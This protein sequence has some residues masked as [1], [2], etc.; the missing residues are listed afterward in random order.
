MFINLLIDILLE[1]NWHLLPWTMEN[2]NNKED[3]ELSDDKKSYGGIPE[4]AFVV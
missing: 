2:I 1:I 4:A 3:I